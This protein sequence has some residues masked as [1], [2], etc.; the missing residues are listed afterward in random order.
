[1]SPRGRKNRAGGRCP[2]AVTR[3]DTGWHF[4]P[5]EANT[6]CETDERR[7]GGKRDQAWLCRDPVPTCPDSELR[8]TGNPPSPRPTTPIPS[9]RSLADTHRKRRGDIL[10]RPGGEGVPK[11]VRSQDFDCV[12]LRR[13]RDKEGPKAESWCGNRRYK[14]E[15]VREVAQSLAKV[16]VFP[17]TPSP[18]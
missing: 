10:A 3:R 7:H 9:G 6:E 17:S 11:H 1:M 8:T 15:V 13:G 5:L 2:G 14:S 12:R 4:E 16:A 18:T